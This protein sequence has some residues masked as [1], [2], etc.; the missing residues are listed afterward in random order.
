M[1]LHFPYD[2]ALTCAEKLGDL[3][4]AAVALDRIVQDGFLDVVKVLSQ[5]ERLA[6]KVR[7]QTRGASG[8]FVE[9]LSEHRIKI[10]VFG[11]DDRFL[12]QVFQLP[13]V[14]W[15]PVGLQKPHTRRRDPASSAPAAG[16]LR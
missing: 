11:E 8:F 16:H 14:S 7:F 5:G 9:V 13:H 6:W 12:E 3:A 1:F 2:A 15:K 10:V 4:G